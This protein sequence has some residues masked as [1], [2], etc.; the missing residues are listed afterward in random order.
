LMRVGYIRIFWT[1]Y[2]NVITV[3][4]GLPIGSFTT[5]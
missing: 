2:L 3:R 4:N 5:E 1:E